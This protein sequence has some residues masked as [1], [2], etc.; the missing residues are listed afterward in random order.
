MCGQTGGDGR[1]VGGREAGVRGN[2]Y[3]VAA[4]VHDRRRQPFQ[5]APLAAC[6]GQ[7]P[8]LGQARRQRGN[9]R[10]VQMLTQ[11]EMVELLAGLALGAGPVQADHGAVPQSQVVVAILNRTHRQVVGLQWPGTAAQCI[12][13]RDDVL[14]AVKPTWHLF[15]SEVQT[16]TARLARLDRLLD[17]H[18]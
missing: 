18:R 16:R 1:L 13:L 11:A 17:H 3:A 9:L 6:G 7:C 12:D 10:V 15:G 5:S 4:V 2:A 14:H 8:V